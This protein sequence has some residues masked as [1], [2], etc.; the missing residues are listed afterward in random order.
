MEYADIKYSKELKNEFPDA[1]MWYIK[2]KYQTYNIL[3]KEGRIIFKDDYPALTTD[4]LL[5]IFPDKV[6]IVYWHGGCR[7]NCDGLPPKKGRIQSFKDKSL[8]NA[9]A[10]MVIYLKKENLLKE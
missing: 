6:Y 7:V 10:K 9:L 1:E 3:P 5:T 8:Q 2:T 4:M